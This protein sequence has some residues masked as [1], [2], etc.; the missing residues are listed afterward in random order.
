MKVGII[1]DV[2]IISVPS[3]T[4]NNEKQSLRNVSN[5]KEN[6]HFSDIDF[7]ITMLDLVEKRVTDNSQIFHYFFH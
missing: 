4:K 2:T 3:F 7:R 1:V 6:E 5:E